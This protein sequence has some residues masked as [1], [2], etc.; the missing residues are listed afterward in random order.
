MEWNESEFEKDM[1]ADYRWQQRAP[2]GERE[3]DVQ[4]CAGESFRGE[5]K[6]QIHRVLGN[7]EWGHEQD[8]A[9]GDGEGEGSEGSDQTSPPGPQDGNGIVQ[10]HRHRSLQVLSSGGAVVVAGTGGI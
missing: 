5:R 2:K 3:G 4:R 7:R 6:L 9:E 1:H 10:E 8:K